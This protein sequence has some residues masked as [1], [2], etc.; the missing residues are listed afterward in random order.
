MQLHNLLHDREDQLLKQTRRM[1]SHDL[2]KDYGLAITATC[3]SCTTRAKKW[4]KLEKTLMGT[5][6]SDG[7]E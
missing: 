4:G 2:S 5:G 6:E 7:K 1:G 3:Q